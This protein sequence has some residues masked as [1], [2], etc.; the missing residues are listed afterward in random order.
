MLG[1]PMW[2]VRRVT[3][4]P[5]EVLL[6]ATGQGPLEARALI[7]DGEILVPYACLVDSSTNPVQLSVCS[8]CGQPGCESGGWV[9]LRS[10]GDAVLLLP[11]FA[12]DDPDYLEMYAPP[13]PI[14]RRGA[15]LL[16]GASFDL[17]RQHLLGLP[18]ASAL[19]A[20]QTREAVLCLQLEAPL[21]VLGAPR[22][23]V[24]IDKSV[25]LACSEDD[26][27]ELLDEAE[28]LLQDLAG[29]TVPVVVHAPRG[30]PV[31]LYLDG[32]KTTTW[33]PF[34]RLPSGRLALHL[35]EDLDVGRA[36]ETGAA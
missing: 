28:G 2:N 23:P 4:A 9:T 24:S 17:M 14:Q 36:T 31:S 34:A 11:R 10:V 19:P 16:N 13:E 22:S 30:V 32:P 25:V 8:Y 33:T 26:V 1:R 29:K 18:A 21:A 12:V 35:S 27:G 3:D 7:A 20:L 5:A 6:S 15:A